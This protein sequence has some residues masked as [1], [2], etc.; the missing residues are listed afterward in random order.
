MWIGNPFCKAAIRVSKRF[1][2]YGYVFDKRF[3]F[4]STTAAGLNAIRLDL[5]DHVLPLLQDENSVYA[6]YRQTDTHDRTTQPC[7]TNARSIAFVLPTRGRS[8][9]RQVRSALNKPPAK[10]DIGHES[11]EVK[12]TLKDLIRGYLPNDILCW[13]CPAYAEQSPPLGQNFAELPR[14]VFGKNSE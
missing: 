14:I 8:D 9:L 6:N 3:D 7:R 13:D 10:E 1:G 11:S 12:A 2:E 5:F 4:R